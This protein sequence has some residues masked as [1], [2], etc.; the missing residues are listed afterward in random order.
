LGP[1]TPPVS[2]DEP[3]VGPEII[4]EK[5]AVEE[6]GEEKAEEEEE[7]EAKEPGPEEVK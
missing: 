7:E 1:E 4:E 2:E 5:K 6:E 3:L